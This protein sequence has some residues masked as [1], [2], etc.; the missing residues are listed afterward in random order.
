M[1]RFNTDDIKQY[2]RTL[3]SL[4]WKKTSNLYKDPYTRLLIDDAKATLRKKVRSGR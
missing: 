4:Y 2:I 3:C 1:K